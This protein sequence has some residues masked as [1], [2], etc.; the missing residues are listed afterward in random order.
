MLK[1]NYDFQSLAVGPAEKEGTSRI[2]TVVPGTDES[3]TKLVHQLYK[4]IDV[5]EVN[6][7][8]AV[9]MIVSNAVGMITINEVLL[10]FFF[11]FSGPGFYS[12]TICC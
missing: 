11:G 5:Y 12:F 1:S 4:L 8:V 2:T 6:I 9:G 10:K 7:N 3:I